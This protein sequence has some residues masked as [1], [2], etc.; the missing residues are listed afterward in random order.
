MSKSDQEFREEFKPLQIPPSFEKAEG[1]EQQTIFL[2]AKLGEAGA[3]EVNEAYQSET[4]QAMPEEISAILGNL[5][6]KGLIKGINSENG[7]VYNLSK[8]TEPNRGYV[9]PEALAP[10]LD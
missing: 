6:E 2:L 3:V 7:I 4:G 1:L 10:G 9:D 5:Y 8:I